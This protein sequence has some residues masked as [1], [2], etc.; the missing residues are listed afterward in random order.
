MDC[1]ICKAQ[2]LGGT[3]EARQETTIRADRF[4]AAGSQR[5]CS[6]VFDKCR[7]DV[8]IGG[9]DD[10]EGTVTDRQIRRNCDRL[11]R[12]RQRLSPSLR[13]LFRSPRERVVQV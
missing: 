7:T 10:A 9:V 1:L 8:K 3:V 5:E 11:F 13:Q 12:E 6:L 2:R 4:W